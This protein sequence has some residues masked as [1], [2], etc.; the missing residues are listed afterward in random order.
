MMAVEDAANRAAKNISSLPMKS[1]NA[2]A[3][4]RRPLSSLLSDIEHFITH[5]RW[6]LCTL[7]LPVRTVNIADP[8][9]FRLLRLAQRWEMTIIIAF[10]IGA[11]WSRDVTDKSCARTLQ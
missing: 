6:P 8:N 10:N 7:S 11:G 9:C 1:M 4:Y 3:N 2:S 5:C